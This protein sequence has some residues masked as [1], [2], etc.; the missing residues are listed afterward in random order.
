MI[1]VY[2]YHTR[3][4]RGRRDENPVVDVLLP[5]PA[6]QAHETEI[7]KIGVEGEK[8]REVKRGFF[9]TLMK[10][11]MEHRIAW[12]P[13]QRKS[14]RERIARIWTMLDAYSQRDLKHLYDLVQHDRLPI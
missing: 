13:D 6:I 8:A 7:M 14:V 11:Y 5:N 10:T 3:R 9:V 1:L 2:A 12:H 4:S